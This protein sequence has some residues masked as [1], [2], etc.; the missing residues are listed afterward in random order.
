VLSSC[1]LRITYQTW[2]LNIVQRGFLDFCHDCGCIWDIRRRY[3]NSSGS[4]GFVVGFGFAIEVFKRGFWYFV[5]I[6]GGFEAK[7]K[8]ATPPKYFADFGPSS[9]Y[10]SFIVEGEL[11]FRTASYFASYEAYYPLIY[12]FPKIW[13]V[14]A[15]RLL[16][17]LSSLSF[18]IFQAT[19]D[20]KQYPNSTTFFSHLLVFN[21][22]GH[23][24]LC[25]HHWM[26]RPLLRYS[27]IFIFA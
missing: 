23:T 21:A 5:D 1:D 12:L 17:P 20:G 18:F 13:D 25:R 11:G 24:L 14:K 7:P 2:D 10:T 26:R 6:V 27:S 9:L 16:Q 15:I 8:T 19:A 4:G 22:C 3:Q